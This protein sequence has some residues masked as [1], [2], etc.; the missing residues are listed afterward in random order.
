MGIFEPLGWAKYMP[1]GD[2]DKLIV[3]AKTIIDELLRV[4]QLDDAP[5]E[6]KYGVKAM[7]IGGE[8][9]HAFPTASA[10]RVVRY[11]PHR[12]QVGATVKPQGV[13]SACG[14]REHG[15]WPSSK[16]GGMVSRPWGERGRF[17]PRTGWGTAPGHVRRVSR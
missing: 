16:A 8:G 15:L 9:V 12:R 14:W 2:L 11:R 13:T 10:G 3:Q 7:Q 1:I 5:V 6:E 17:F 4:A